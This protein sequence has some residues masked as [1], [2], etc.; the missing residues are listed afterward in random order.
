MLRIGLSPVHLSIVGTIELVYGLGLRVSHLGVAVLGLFSVLAQH[1]ATGPTGR[2]VSDVRGW[3][4][5][6]GVSFCSER[7]FLPDPR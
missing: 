5:L 6:A 1:F 7:R 2:S 3:F 4:Q